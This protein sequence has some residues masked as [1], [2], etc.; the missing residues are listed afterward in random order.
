MATDTTGTVI[1]GTMRPQDLIPAFLDELRERDGAAYMQIVFAPFGPVPSDAELDDR[2]EWWASDEA[3]DLLE[4]LFDA[5]GTA[6]P[7][8]FFFGAH[9]GDGS[10]Y[11]F[12]PMEED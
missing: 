1:H 6:A 12:W 3:A 10:D 8:G 2:H 11:G 4:T 7:E 9:P 5:L